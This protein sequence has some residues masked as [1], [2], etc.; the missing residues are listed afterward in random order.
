MFLCDYEGTLI[1]RETAQ[2]QGAFLAHN[3]TNDTQNAT[4]DDDDLLPVSLAIEE[5]WDY[6]NQQPIR[7]AV[8]LMRTQPWI[9]LWKT[10]RMRPEDEISFGSYQWDAF[11]QLCDQPLWLEGV[12]LGQL[13]CKIDLAGDA[14]D[15]FA[16]LTVFGCDL[17]IDS[18][19]NNGLDQPARSDAEELL[20]DDSQA[21]GKMLLVNDGDVTA[22]LIPDFADGLNLFGNQ[23]DGRSPQF[24]PVVLQMQKMDNDQLANL[25]FRFH[26]S[27]SDPAGMSRT[28]NEPYAYTAAPGHLRLWTKN[29]AVSRNVN[30]LADGGDFIA[31]NELYTAV[32]LGF[33]PS[34]SHITLYLEAVREGTVEH[35]A[36]SIKVELDASS[37][38]QV[39]WSCRDD[40]RVTPLRL[41]VT[42]LAE[43]ANP[44]NRIPNFTPKDDAPL[45][46]SNL[47][48]LVA[49]PNG[50]YECTIHARMLPPNQCSM[51]YV[52]CRDA[53]DVSWALTPTVP[54]E[55]LLASFSDGAAP[56]NQRSDYTIILVADMDNSGAI[57]A[58]ERLPACVRDDAGNVIGP[59]G[60]RCTPLQQYTYDFGE[61]D[62]KVNSWYWR[63]II[64]MML[65]DAGALLRVYYEGNHAFLYG[66][67]SRSP[68]AVVRRALSAFETATPSSSCFSEW[69][70]H[71][72]GAPFDAQGIA[73]PSGDAGGIIELNWNP[74]SAFAQ[75]VA[76]AQPINPFLN[77]YVQ[78]LNAYYE[79]TIAP[80]ALEYFSQ[81]PYAAE[82]T[83]PLSNEWDRNFLI[84][85]NPVVVQKNPQLVWVPEH[86]ILLYDR[87]HDEEVANPDNAL[88]AIGRG[89]LTDMRRKFVFERIE[90]EFA[91]YARLKAIWVA[92]ALSDLYDF[93]Q[94]TQGIGRHAATMQ[95]GFGCGS[96]E[97]NKGRIFLHNILFE[98][99]LTA[100]YIGTQDRFFDKQIPSQ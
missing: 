52:I 58:H 73:A 84:E 13:Q 92:G 64:G 50:Q 99:E 42:R 93:N 26:Y 70:T 16:N 62:D 90:K 88:L 28:G 24:V 33:T 27:G 55:G 61:I 87:C 43:T 15:D 72:A 9:K 21:S 30:S 95:L 59:A 100:S 69:L 96:T 17:D 86:T 91:Q 63:I 60:L 35:A 94:D 85:Q 80:A 5:G 47:L 12:A 29:G 97:R 68:V 67:P 89:R 2:A 75:M 51:G 1:P 48:Y 36:H 14:E 56:P 32:Q 77:P 23:G 44:A 31:S 81:N 22:N 3:W 10:R 40:L 45:L 38:S 78:Q 37:G 82:V 46:P 53:L 34:Q 8:Q 98:E 19:N 4:L 25:T 57:E 74:A 65:P 41:E 18:D 71:N 76:K 11:A 20:E 7:P 83:M 39:Q 66:D 49:A 54:N 6:G 79:S